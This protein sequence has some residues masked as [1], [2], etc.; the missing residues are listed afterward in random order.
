MTMFTEKVEV[1]DTDPKKYTG[2]VAISISNTLELLTDDYS[3]LI[4]NITDGIEDRSGLLTDRITSMNKLLEAKRARLERQFAAM[5]TALASL[6]G[7]Q[8]SLSTLA[9]IA[10]SYQK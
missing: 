5:E 4:A 7:Q 9:S 8:S 6:Q 2:G 3:G 10:S 1:E